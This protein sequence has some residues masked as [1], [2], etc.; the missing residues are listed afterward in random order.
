MST[1]GRAVHPQEESKDS[2]T[3]AAL[4]PCRHRGDGQGLDQVWKACHRT[5]E[6]ERNWTGKASRCP[7]IPSARDPQSPHMPSVLSPLG[8]CF[9]SPMCTWTFLFSTLLHYFSSILFVSFTLL[10][11][12]KDRLSLHRCHQAVRPSPSPGH[13]IPRACGVVP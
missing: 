4:G 8:H 3:A 11:S 12:G 1:A 2:G 13:G 9:P 7:S 6:P 5:D 10:H